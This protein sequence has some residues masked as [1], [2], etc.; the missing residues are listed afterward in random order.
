MKKL[1]QTIIANAVDLGGVKLVDGAVA[2][3]PH[4][5]AAAGDVPAVLRSITLHDL[6]TKGAATV[7][8]DREILAALR[9]ASAVERART[10]DPHVR[11]LEVAARLD[12]T[13]STIRRRMAH[14]VK[15]GEITST[16]K[17]AG[18]RYAPAD[19]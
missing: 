7:P 4:L 17:A 13:T 14:M 10:G 1:R 3:V 11:A 9:A 12:V 16:G 18:K 5:G 19:V 2:A 8:L 15:S 6:V